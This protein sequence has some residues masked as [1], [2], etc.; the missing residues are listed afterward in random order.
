[1]NR[2][3]RETTLSLL[4]QQLSERQISGLDC[5]GLGI[6]LIC[7][8]TFKRIETPVRDP[9][10]LH[11]QCFDLSSKS[12]VYLS[13]NCPICSFQSY[14]CYYYGGNLSFSID[15]FMEEILKKVP[16]HIDRVVLKAD[17]SWV[18]PVKDPSI[19]LSFDQRSVV[20]I[21]DLT[22][23]PTD[24][25][26]DHYYSSVYDDTIKFESVENGLYFATNNLFRDTENWLD[27]YFDIYISSGEGDDNDDNDDD[28]AL[29]EFSHVSF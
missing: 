25:Y 24:D 11:V 15:S 20:D 29:Y 27:V 6:S 12:I 10:C 3:P 14:Y 7:P 22:Q 23:L 5:E 4:R 26:S 19:D 9:A 8:V 28:D 16:K 13:G 1:M 21:I 17:G 18:L 2:I